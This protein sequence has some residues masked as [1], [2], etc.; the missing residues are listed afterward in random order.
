[1]TDEVQGIFRSCPVCGAR[2]RNT[3]SSLYTGA[4]CG[5][6]GW[7]QGVKIE[8][9]QELDTAREA[10]A[11]QLWL[12]LQ[13]SQDWRDSWD[14]WS[15]RLDWLID[16]TEAIAQIGIADRFDQLEA[17]ITARLEAPRDPDPAIAD[18]LPLNSELGLDYTP[19]AIALSQA[20]WRTADDITHQL[21]NDAIARNRPPP[22]ASPPPLLATPAN[23]TPIFDDIARFPAT[24]LQ[25]LAWLWAAY[26][27][28]RF[29]WVAQISQWTDDYGTFCDRVGW[30]TSR[31]W[32][33]YDEL[34]F[35]PETLESIAIGHF[36][37]LG[38]RKR[39]CY[40]VGGETAAGILL[41]WFDRWRQ[42]SEPD[43]M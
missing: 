14:Y 30:R 5:V 35:E 23:A 19:L 9:D 2:P 11:R 13:A 21:I 29:G 28:G 6:C 15:Q 41:A 10:W 43:P 20:D 1:M 38:W 26:S 24:D 3:G 18:E 33:Y 42:I 25:T 32:L 22:T 36:P 31:G 8:A 4:T 27:D 37:V 17:R 39:S 40:G 7:P 12:T 34:Q 16:R